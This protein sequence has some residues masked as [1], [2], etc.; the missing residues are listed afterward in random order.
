[1]ASVVYALCGL[2][3]TGCAVLLVR[4]YRLSRGR[5]LLWASICFIGLA[6]NNIVLFVDKVVVADQSLAAWR[7]IPQV[8]GLAAFALGLVWEAVAER[9]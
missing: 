6:L 9:R 3:A 8:V 5:L 2:T 1:M 7:T 4:S